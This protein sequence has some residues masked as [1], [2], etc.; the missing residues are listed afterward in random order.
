[1]IEIKEMLAPQLEI[2]LAAR[3]VIKHVAENGNILHP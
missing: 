3:R 2:L 1:M